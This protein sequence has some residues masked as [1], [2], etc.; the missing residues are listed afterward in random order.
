M[1][2]K[3]EFLSELET[4]LF[5]VGDPFSIDR[6]AKA[7]DTDKETV[8]VA[9]EALSAR[10][11]SPESGLILIRLGE[12]VQLG[13]KPSNA[14]AIER[15]RETELQDGLSRAAL[16]TLAVIAYRSPVTRADIDIIRG[17][18]SNF[19][20]RYLLIRGL[21]EREGNPLDARGYI[22]RPTFD[23]LKTLGVG[24]ITELPEYELLSQDERLTRLL[25]E[26]VSTEDESPSSP[27]VAPDTSVPP[28]PVSNI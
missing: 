14:K 22:Y 23:F 20:L 28:H 27:E 5:A 11:D 4:L 26:D 10:Y 25:T 21:I 1:D 17:V 24:K 7:L 18:N 9:L 8:N 16:E 15:L 19:T 13:S 12:K 3:P 6:L 2:M